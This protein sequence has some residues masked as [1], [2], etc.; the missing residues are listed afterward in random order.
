MNLNDVSFNFKNKKVIVVGGSRGIGLQV[1]KSFLFS[2]AEVTCLSRTPP[3]VD[4]INFLKCD[5]SSEK[6]IDAA[7][8]KISKI[9]FLINVAGTNLC[10][11][12]ENIDSLEWDRV[13]DINLKSFFLISKKAIQLMRSFK[14]GR[15]VNVSS[16]AGRNKSLVSGVHYTSSKY[17]IVGLTKQMANETSKDGIL[18][19][20]V[21]PSQTKTEMLKES[22]TQSEIKSLEEKI[23]IKRIATCSEQALPILFLCSSAASYITGATLD[24]NGGQF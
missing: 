24:I 2:G 13:M 16:I 1:L 17:G 11:G 23:P 14:Y 5:I 19:N 7:F 9:D 4:G 21:C 10:D 12:V 3:P 18:I 8:T 15:I 20:C 6:E 22:M